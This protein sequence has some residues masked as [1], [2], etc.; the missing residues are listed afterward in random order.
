MSIINSDILILGSGVAGLS[1]AIK[2]AAAMPD[3]SIIVATKAEESESNT[4]YAQGGIAAVWDK[5]D[6][7]EDH[8]KDTL[9]AGD[10]MSDH[11]VVR[12]VVEEAPRCMEQ[13]IEWGTDFDQNKEGEID[14]GKEGG[15]SA[16]RILHYKDITG[17]EVEKTLLEQVEKLKNIQV[18]PFHFA[19]DL[20]TDHHIEGKDPKEA[21]SCYG[22]YILDQKTNK[23]DTYL[24]NTVVLATGGIGQVY[25]ATTNPVIATGDGIAMA[26]RA[27]AKIS[28]MEFVQFHPTSLY[29]PGQSPSFLISE[30]VRGFGAY[31]RNKAGDRFMLDIDERA[32]LAPRDIVSR[33]INSEL[34]F[35]GD[36]HVYLD[37]THLDMP[38]FK[39]HFP[40]IF[41]K[42]QSLGINP[43]TQWI[44]VVP[45]AHYLMGGIEVDKAGQSSVSNLFACG[46]CSRTGLH[47]AN[48]LASNSLL[49]ALVY[50]NNIAEEIINNRSHLGPELIPDI[51]E[52]NE[53]GTMV[54]RENVL[55]SHNRKTIQNIMTDLVAIVRSNERLEK[56]IDHL[57][58]LYQDTEKAYEKSK[59]SPQICELRNLNAVAYLIVSQ[60]M[61]RKE[62]K[63]AF[64]SLDNIE[65]E[66]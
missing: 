34:I 42:C 1:I 35:T 65:V 66:D 18:L 19:I 64:F 47:G 5:L 59:L 53:E 32:E 26:Y 60:S 4:K 8:V 45:A 62:N 9:V 7:F 22:A 3:K 43:E 11:E 41:E 21:I 52:W 63:G 25:A 57:N 49:E 51:P 30:A 58:Y 54:P 44:P 15:H 61:E 17:W 39:K 56:A 29:Q 6:S 2:S 55:I 14:L 36:P 28:E 27:K 48:R 24:S 38:E 10:F 13:L 46:E 12:M 50:G 23:I 20:I 40:N 16:N 31:L 37:C 33:A